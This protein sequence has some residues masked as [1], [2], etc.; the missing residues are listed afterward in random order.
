MS[1]VDLMGADRWVPAEQCTARSKT[2]GR[3]CGRMTRGGGVCRYHG[4][5]SPQTRARREVR[6]ATAQA[7]RLFAD[8]YAERDPAEVLLGAVADLDAMA[9]R[10]K[11]QIERSGD[12]TATDYV[13]LRDAL[14]MA[15]RWSKA[16]L[17]ARV[18][19]RRVRIGEQ[20]GQQVA[21][22]IK[23]ILTDLG[24]SLADRRVL[25]V[26]STRLREL[27]S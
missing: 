20:Q 1:G 14:E 17:D 21:G 5:N 9:Q 8:D 18:D 10:I 6:I 19:E 16:V 3:R 25:Q 7:R 27:Q 4:G 23:A 13:A 11:D 22:A 26:V 12:W 15:A 24:H 2:S